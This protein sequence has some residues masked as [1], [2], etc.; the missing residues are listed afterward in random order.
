MPGAD[1]L[2]TNKTCSVMLSKLHILLKQKLDS[3]AVLTYRDLRV[4]VYTHY[5]TVGPQFE[6]IVEKAEESVCIL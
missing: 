4:A 3:S 5:N 1:K 2:H 6:A